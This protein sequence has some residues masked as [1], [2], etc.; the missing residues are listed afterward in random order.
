MEST[1]AQATPETD[2]EALESNKLDYNGN[3]KFIVINLISWYCFVY[4]DFRDDAPR[5]DDGLT[6]D[7]MSFR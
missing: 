4:F 7:S 1:L 3:K 6:G 2:V 5:Y